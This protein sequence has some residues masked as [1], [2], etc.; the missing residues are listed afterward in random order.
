MKAR[1]VDANQSEIVEALRAVGAS[2]FLLHAVGAGCP[3]LLVGFCGVNYLMELKHGR[4][5]KLTP[6]EHKFFDEWNGYASII[7]T[8]DDALEEIGMVI[9]T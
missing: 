8:V 7:R 6:A 5:A 4:Y 1:K 9:Q 3:D 2:V